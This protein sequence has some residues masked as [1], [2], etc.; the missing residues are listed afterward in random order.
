M[1]TLKSDEDQLNWLKYINSYPSNSNHKETY[2]FKTT[3]PP[4]SIA[5]LK[6]FEGKM[7]DIV[8]NVK[9]KHPKHNDLQIKMNDNIKNIKNDGIP[10]Y[11]KC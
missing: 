2:G 10:M 8:Q 1:L 4:P 6:E 5:E 3:T 9:F 7:Y 11:A